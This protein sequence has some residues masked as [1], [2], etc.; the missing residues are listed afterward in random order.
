MRD[1]RRKPHNW[2]ESFSIEFL[3]FIV[4]YEMGAC[5]FVLQTFGAWKTSGSFKAH[6]ASLVFEAILL[7]L[8]ILLIKI[9]HDLVNLVS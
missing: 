3:I 7:Q 5:F 4:N 1:M 8:L 9:P 2:D 6:E